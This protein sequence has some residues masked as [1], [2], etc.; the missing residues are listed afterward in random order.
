[1]VLKR[2]NWLPQNFASKCIFKMYSMNFLILLVCF[3]GCNVL[4]HF[5][6][7]FMIFTVFKIMKNTFLLTPSCFERFNIITKQ[8][9]LS[10]KQCRSTPL[11]YGLGAK[12]HK[13]A[14][15][16]AFKLHVGNL[17]M[18]IQGHISRTYRWKTYW[19][20]LFYKKNYFIK[21]IFKKLKVKIV[22]LTVELYFKGKNLNSEFF[23][24]LP[25][26]NDLSYKRYCVNTVLLFICVKYRLIWT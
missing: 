15:F 19:P 7:V 14:I 18:S 11:R 25:E 2:E 12:R 10:N 5:F 13:L 4:G 23:P 24:I 22:D 20:L 3:V 8:N 26:L 6:T 17:T 16:L 1:M 21:L 9:L